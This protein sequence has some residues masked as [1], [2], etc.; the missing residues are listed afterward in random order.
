MGVSETTPAHDAEAP[1]SGS[2]PE[3]KMMELDFPGALDVP[4]FGSPLCI[5]KPGGSPAAHGAQHGHTAIQP[6]CP[7][8]GCGSDTERKIVAEE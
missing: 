4:V 2:L 5:L 1:S 7:R 6:E 3:A 8:T